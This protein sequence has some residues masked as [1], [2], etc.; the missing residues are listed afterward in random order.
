MSHSYS[1]YSS[2]SPARYEQE[3]SR[4]PSREAFLAFRQ[5]QIELG[6][7]FPLSASSMGKSEMW[8]ARVRRLS[9]MDRASIDALSPLVQDQ[10][11]EGMRIVREETRRRNRDGMD[12]P[13]S[14]IELLANN[15]RFLPAADAFCVA[16]FIDPVLVSHP[17][18]LARFPNAYLVTD[19]AA[20][21]RVAFFL[22]C[23][24]AHSEAAKRLKLFRPRGESTISL[25]P[26]P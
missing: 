10:I 3:E 8:L 20:E 26:R 7:E 25:D 19:I 24:D 12:D 15:E 6:Y 11:W 16:S 4:M 5:K 21:D 2:P 23:S 18:D 14:L 9:T 1:T 22:A 17:S 13:E